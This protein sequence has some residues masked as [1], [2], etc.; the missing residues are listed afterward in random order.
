LITALSLV[1]RAF[2]HTLNLQQVKPDNLSLINVVKPEDNFAKK[3]RKDVKDY[4]DS[5]FKQKTWDVNL[6]P[7]EK[8]TWVFSSNQD[9]DPNNF[10]NWGFK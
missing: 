9:Y 4:K 5:V 8:Y 1:D 7:H 3:L 2:N 6:L 10:K